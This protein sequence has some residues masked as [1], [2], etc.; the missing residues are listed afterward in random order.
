MIKLLLIA[1][2]VFGI[3]CLAR[4]GVKAARRARRS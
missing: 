2:I 1:V 3:I 4:D